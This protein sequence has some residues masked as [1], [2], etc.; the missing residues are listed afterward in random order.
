I[1]ANMIQNKTGQYEGAIILED[2]VIQHIPILLRIAEGDVITT[3]KNGQLDFTVN[4]QK[5]WSYAKISVF[6]DDDRLVN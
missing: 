4:S 6:N 3:D 2:R 1:K 5:E